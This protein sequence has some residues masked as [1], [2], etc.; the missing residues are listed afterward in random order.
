VPAGP[1]HAES[2]RQPWTDWPTFR[3]YVLAECDRLGAPRPPDPMLRIRYIDQRCEM[4][5]VAA[6]GEIHQWQ[7]QQQEGGETQVVPVVSRDGGRPAP[8]RW[9]G[10]TR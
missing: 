6:W 9:R 5:R 2:K 1:N 7:Q 10:R 8:R 4:A 3:A